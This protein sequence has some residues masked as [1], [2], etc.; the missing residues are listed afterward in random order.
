MKEK[1]KWTGEIR[2]RGDRRRKKIGRK[3]EKWSK[4]IYI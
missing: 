2:E 4:R 3:K 1:E